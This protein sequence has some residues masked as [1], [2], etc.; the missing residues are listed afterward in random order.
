MVGFTQLRHPRGYATAVEHL[1]C[2]ARALERWE[3]AARLLAA[4]DMLFDLSSQASIPQWQ[5]DPGK[6][7]AAC[8]ANLGERAVQSL[9]A[10]PCP[11]TVQFSMRSSRTRLGNDTVMQLAGVSS[12]VANRRSLAWSPRGLAIDGLR[13]P[14]S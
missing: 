5:L 6:I 3:R 2:V 14:W 7:A 11:S 13:R 9:P 10:A 1:A 4:A 8:R 12:R